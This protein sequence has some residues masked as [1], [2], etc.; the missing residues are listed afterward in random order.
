VTER[1]H[2]LR[3]ELAACA[4]AA[5]VLLT[6]LVFG[7][8]ALRFHRATLGAAWFS[9]ASAPL[10]AVLAVE[11]LALIVMGVSLARQVVRQHTFRTRLPAEPRTI[12]GV[13]V[14]V[15]ASRRPH[16]FCVGFLR[17]RIFVSDGLLELLSERELLSVIAHERHHARRRDP[18]RR[19]VIKA[20]CDGFWFI[21][22]LRNTSRTHAAISELAA[23]A[24]AIRS[25]GS[26][27]LAA[28]LVAFDEHSGGDSGA[29]AERVSHLLGV[30]T[31]R[32][33]SALTMFVA[34]TVLLALAGAA[35]YLL[36][37]VPAELCF[38]LSTALGAPL[39]V[40]V[41]GI[42]CVPA[43]LLGRRAANYVRAAATE[44][45]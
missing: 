24:V 43:G 40:L 22:A 7:I 44:L 14:R 25:A 26:R 6:M 33:S 16:A 34:A 9:P 45:A 42:A 12:L 17:P 3:L 11:C 35:L 13:P 23:D 37:P 4:L 32:S 38:P 41:L 27:S 30:S 19:A 5:T 15:I 36:R 20:M 29:S 39:A 21:P 1:G 18:L 31:K 10:F 2:L 28:A 8:D